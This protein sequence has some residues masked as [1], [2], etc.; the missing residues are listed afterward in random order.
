MVLADGTIY[1]HTGRI[2]F[3]DASFSEETGTFLI[4]AE[5][6]NQDH[7]LRPGQF[8]R[9][10]LKGAI[11]PN[12]ILVPQPA[13]QQGAKGSFV[14]VVDKEGKVEFRPIVVSFWYEDQWFVDEGLRDGETVVVEGALKLR[15]GVPVRIVEPEQKQAATTQQAQDGDPAEQ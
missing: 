9:A 2:T 14:W 15:A 7:E 4:R 5:V 10:H 11:R 6:A 8:V 13:V 3:A 12:A 1:P